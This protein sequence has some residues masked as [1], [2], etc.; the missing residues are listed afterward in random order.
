MPYVIAAPDM[1]TT[2]AAEVARIGSSLNEANSAAEA[3][4]TEMIAAGGDEV[5]AAVAAVFSSHGKAFQTLSAQAAAHHSQFAQTLKASAGAYASTEAGN[6]MLVPNIAV[7]VG[8]LTFRSGS[9]T[10]TPQ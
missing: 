1:L 8:G 5:S 2:A 6:A 9:A 3:A 10:A 7:S 4:T